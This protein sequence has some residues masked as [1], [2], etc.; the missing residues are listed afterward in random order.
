MRYY[1]IRKSID[2]SVDYSKR[3]NWGTTD[4]TMLPLVLLRVCN[5][6]MG[7]HAVLTEH[8]YPE[9]RIYK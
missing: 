6:T 2:F 1:V 5:A 8:F 3:N 7:Q 9:Q 4:Y